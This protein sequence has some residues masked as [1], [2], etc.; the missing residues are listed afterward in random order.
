MQFKKSPAP[1]SSFCFD[2]QVLSSQRT[3]YED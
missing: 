2:V 3:D 1:E